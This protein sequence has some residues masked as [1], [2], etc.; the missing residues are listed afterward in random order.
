MRLRI[1]ERLKFDRVDSN[2]INSQAWLKLSNINV[3]S[4]DYELISGSVVINRCYDVLE[5]IL[6][7]PALYREELLISH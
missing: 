4:F 5:S 1:K 7:V 6:K 2:N 3:L